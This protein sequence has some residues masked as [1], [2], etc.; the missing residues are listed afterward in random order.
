MKITIY[1]WSTSTPDTSPRPKLE[2]LWS[3]TA[4]GRRERQSHADQ[5]AVRASLTRGRPELD[6]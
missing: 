4:H 1:R 5:T 3:T 6:Y 2:Y